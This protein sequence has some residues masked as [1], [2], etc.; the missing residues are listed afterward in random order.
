MDTK[1][2]DERWV[3][4]LHDGTHHSWFGLLLYLLPSLETLAARFFSGW[5]VA[6]ICPTTKYMLPYNF[7]DSLYSCAMFASIYSAAF[8]DIHSIAGLRNVKDLELECSPADWLWCCLPNLERIRL[9]QETR[10]IPYFD[11]GD[12]PSHLGGLYAKQN[13]NVL[14]NA[15][16][17]FSFQFD[18][19]PFAFRALR[20]LHLDLINF[21]AHD[22]GQS[23]TK[24][25]AEHPGDST[26]LMARLT[27]VAYTLEKLRITCQDPRLD[28]ET[29]AA[30][31]TP[32]PSCPGA[33]DDGM[34][35]KKGQ[36]ILIQGGIFSIG[37][38]M[39]VLAN[40]LQM[41]IDHVLINDVTVDC[42]MKLVGTDALPDTLKACKAKVVA[43]FVRMLSNYW[44]VKEFYPMQVKK[45]RF[46]SF[47]QLKEVH[48]RMDAGLAVGGQT[49]LVTILSPW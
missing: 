7:L 24:I 2:V 19:A 14:V 26:H 12:T 29:P 45:L 27:P 39:I 18:W 44:T 38:A 33:R 15:P 34:G 42:A 22:R 37:M 6:K 43:Y 9:G 25:D 30:P 5:A 17:H 46:A 31:H 49:V 21:I 3:K 11:F 13:T 23:L 40:Q 47:E 28:E 16:H 1:R 35:A 10:I 36:S 4:N 20:Q 48:E 32:A 8:P 41:T